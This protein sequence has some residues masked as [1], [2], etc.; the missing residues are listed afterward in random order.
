MELEGGTWEGQ[1]N[2]GFF[3]GPL[4]AVAITE[5][6]AVSRVG[7]LT[8]KFPLCYQGINIRSSCTAKP[9]DIH[10]IIFA[11]SLR[12]GSRFLFRF[13]LELGLLDLFA[14]S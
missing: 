4:V 13:R 9:L 7:N 14:C 8:T 10:I 12:Y 2:V 5:V 6:P 11:V 3:C 1:R